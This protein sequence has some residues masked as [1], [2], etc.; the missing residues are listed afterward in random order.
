MIQCLYEIR[1]NT[2]MLI[3]YKERDVNERK[4]TERYE[5]KPLSGAS[6]F[7]LELGNP[8]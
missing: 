6:S 2:V 1:E 7:Q 3:Q 8:S 5:I 4:A